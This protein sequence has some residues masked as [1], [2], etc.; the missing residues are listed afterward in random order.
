MDTPNI[1][2]QAPIDQPRVISPVARR[3]SGGGLA[4][5]VMLSLAALAGFAGGLAAPYASPFLSK[6]CPIF[7]S[8][9]A[10]QQRKDVAK[11]KVN[12]IAEDEMITGVVEKSS[13]SVVSIVIT[14]DVPR[15]R[16]YFSNPFGGMMPF[17]SDPFNV[18]GNG[19]GSTEKQQIGSGSGFIVSSDGLIVTNKHVVSDMQAEYTVITNDGQEHQ[20]TVLAR[21]P[22]NDI[23]IIKIEGKDFPALP[24]G[25]SDVIKVGQSVLAIGN[26]LGE[27]ANSVSRGIISGLKRSV[28]AGSGLRGDTEKLTG[29]IQIDAAINPGN[30]GG[31][32]LNLQGEVI[33]IDVAMAQGAENIGFA[34]PINSVKK[35]IEEVRT[36]GKISTPYL[37]VRYIILSGEISKQNNLPFGYGALVLRGQ[38]ITDFAV[39]PGSPADKAGIVEND[40]VLEIGGQK[41][42]E[43]HPLAS[44]ISQHK[45]G[46]QVTIKVWHKGET[47]EITVTLEE[48]R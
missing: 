48:R 47:K 1:P 34:L 4:L 8:M 42:D 23:A 10:E 11:E 24:L 12:V 2:E 28:S 15:A 40:I 45:A 38:A 27:F 39:V 16:N 32:L 29:I 44:L 14:K 13:P 7:R 25:D 6:W 20:A 46:D 19:A 31:P 18:Q 43:E 37:G 5:L 30:S 17:F 22:N 36:T 9:V 41:V 26:P 35:V 33:G 21:D 3:K